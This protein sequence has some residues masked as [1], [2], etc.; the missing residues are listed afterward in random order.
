MIPDRR[1]GRG[2]PAGAEPALQDADTIAAVE[3]AG[4]QSVALPAQHKGWEGAAG[5][6]GGPRHPRRAAMRDGGSLSRRATDKRR[7][8]GG[9]GR[10]RAAAD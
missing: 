8:I 10:P 5:Q 7:K 2:R 4:G 9:G 1:Y 3:G 6:S